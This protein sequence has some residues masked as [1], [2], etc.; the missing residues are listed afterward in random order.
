MRD[1][2]IVPLPSQH[3][4]H[5]HRPAHEGQESVAS[6]DQSFRVFRSLRLRKEELYF[7]DEA[8]QELREVLF[9]LDDLFDVAIQAFDQR[10]VE[11][12]K[13]VD[14]LEQKVD[15]YAALLESKHIERVKKGECQAQIGSIYLQTISNLER[16]GDHI[17]NLAFSLRHYRHIEK[18]I[19]KEI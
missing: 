11:L 15:E 18:K 19:P 1:P 5:L 2:S 3:I 13:Q 16:V 8:V 17:T 6:V 10:D 12:L 9:T 14:I 7:S 4:P